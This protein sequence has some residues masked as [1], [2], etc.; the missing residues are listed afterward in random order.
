MMKQKQ[1]IKGNGRLEQTKIFNIFKINLNL[2][3]FILEIIYL[4]KGAAFLI[5]PDE[6]KPMGVHWITLYVRGFFCN[7]LY[8][9]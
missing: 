5:N 2:K 8:Y 4:K 9:L 7:I 3:V 6:N 1:R